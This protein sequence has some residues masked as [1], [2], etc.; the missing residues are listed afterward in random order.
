[1]VLTIGG[2][3][4]SGGSG[5]QADLKALSALRIYGASV[6]TAVTAQNSRGVGD[7][8]PVPGTVVAAQLSA[9]LDDLPVDAV[10]TGMFASAEACAAVTARARG[11][12]LPNLVVD[13][14]LVTA[15]GS[16]MAVR[17][18]LERLLGYAT[19]ATPD[20]EEASA[21]L[22]WQVATPT[23]MAGAAGQLAAGGPRCVVI[24]GGDFVTGEETVD[25]VWVDGHARFLRAPRVNTRNTRGSGATFATAIAARLALGAPPLDAVVRAKSFVGQAIAAAANWRVGAGAAPVDPF[26]WAEPADPPAGP[27]VQVD[28]GPGGPAV[29]RAAAPGGAADPSRVA[30]TPVSRRGQPPRPA[31]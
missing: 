22:G 29:G 2:S 18:A 19:V 3:D 26:G 23:D 14:V 7:V 8:L 1:V 11:G 12:G 13:P 24:T 17:A 5:L 9:V 10:K 27:P 31:P 15:G 4:S 21:I 16:R 25:A 28:G 6:V 30:A 20:R